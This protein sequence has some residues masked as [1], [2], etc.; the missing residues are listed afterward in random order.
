MRLFIVVM[1]FI[2]VLIGVSAIWGFKSVS[3]VVAAPPPKAK[4]V[5]TVIDVIDTPISQYEGSNPI[6][7]P[8]VFETMQEAATYAIQES[9]DFST[10]FEYGG[11][12]L[13]GPNNEY[14]VTIPYTIGA[15]DHMLIKHI[16]QLGPYNGVADYHTHPCMPYTHI[17]G[18]F[19]DPDI[20]DYITN[21]LIG[22]MGDLCTGN[23]HEFNADID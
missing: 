10:Q 6:L 9:Y 15:D 11:M 16:H 18:L 21:G 4:V 2:S 20:T 23:V 14:R 7:D 1:L 3:V 12:I 17:P 5:P 13:K 19:S 8:R 22:Y